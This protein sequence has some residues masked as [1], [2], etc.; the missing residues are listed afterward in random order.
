MSSK[1]SKDGISLLLARGD[2][3]VF[4]CF[5]VVDERFKANLV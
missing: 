1:I 5:V 4:F 2:A 3:R